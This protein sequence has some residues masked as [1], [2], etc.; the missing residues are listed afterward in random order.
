M[1]LYLC[2]RSPNF[3]EIWS[4]NTRDVMNINKPYFKEMYVAN[5][6]DIRRVNMETGNK[7]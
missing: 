3:D 1:T 2:R 6:D 7:I 4:A 5:V